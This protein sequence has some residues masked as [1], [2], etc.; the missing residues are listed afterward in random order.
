MSPVDRVYFTTVR[1]SSFTVRSKTEGTST[2]FFHPD[3]CVR[4]VGGGGWSAG[5]TG[6]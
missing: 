1:V 2:L 5:G 6:A 3:R 4:A